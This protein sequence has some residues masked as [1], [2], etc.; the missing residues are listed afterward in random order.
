MASRVTIQ[1]IADALGISRNTVS[2]AI[3]NSAGLA[4][5]TREKIL[6]KATEMGYKQFSYINMMAQA[7]QVLPTVAPDTVEPSPKTQ[8]PVSTWGEIA[9]FTRGILA[10]SHFGT[11]MLDK[12][13]RELLQMGYTMSMHRVS[14]AELENLQ[15]PMTFQPDRTSGILCAEILDGAY[16][17]ML[18]SLNIPVVFA[19]AP[20]LLGGKPLQAD[21]ILMDNTTGIIEFVRT[22]LEKGFT[23]IGF[24]GHS[25]HCQ[26]FYERY[27]A[28][29]NAMYLF[30]GT[31]QEQFC[32]IGTPHDQEYPKP[33]DY[34]QYVKSQIEA[35]DELPEVIICAN[36][37]VAFD[38]MFACRQLG[39]SI[40]EQIQLCGFDDSPESQLY[41]PSL[42]T[43]HI[44]SQIMGLSAVNLL[45]TRM[46]QP[47]MN[48]R[49]LYTETELIYRES[50][51]L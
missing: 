28:F 24:V 49:T 10:N 22:R 36:D 16:A 9:V 4:E 21:R 41:M 8:T 33:M 20:V 38:V 12:C 7:P 6:Q 34:R 5:T 37:F 40:P 26:S 17:Q 51:P 42:T 45:L 31:I 43:I 1:D 3:N 47:E 27:M 18:C 35:L 46:Q 14:S 25:Q 15:L 11:I 23:R 39:I 19:D 44:H 48:Y 30:G 29:R 50:A 13:Q 2:K 32:I